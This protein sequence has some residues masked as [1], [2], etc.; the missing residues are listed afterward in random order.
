[1]SKKVSKKLEAVS[2][3]QEK[4]PE[5]TIRCTCVEIVFHTE[6][7]LDGK[8]AGDIKPSASKVYEKDFNQ[9]IHIGKMADMACEQLMKQA[10]ESN[11]AG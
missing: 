10:A 3:V 2:E 8:K 7:L 11:G 1:M 4:Q 6:V 9:E 5:T